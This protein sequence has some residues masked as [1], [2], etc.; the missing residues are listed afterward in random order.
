MATTSALPLRRLIHVLLIALTYPHLFSSECYMYWAPSTIPGA[1]LGVFAGSKSYEVGDQVTFGDLVIPIWDLDWH[2][3]HYETRKFLWDEY[4]WGPEVFDGM[5]VEVTENDAIYAASIGMGA[6]PN[7]LLP[8]INLYDDPI[9]LDNAG[10]DSTSPGVGSFTPYH[11]RVYRAS[12]DIQP[13]MELFVNYG[14]NYFDSRTHIYGVMPFEEDYTRADKLLLEYLRFKDYYFI[15]EHADREGENDETDY[16]AIVPDLWSVLQDFKSIWTESTVLMAVPEEE[17]IIKELM[18][19]GGTKYTLYDRSIRDIAWLEEHGECM[20]NIRDGTSTIPHA[21]RGAFANRK[22]PKGSLVSPVP[23]IH[24]SD[25]DYLT[26]YEMT[27]YSLTP[28][29]TVPVHSQLL[30]N[31]CFGHPQSQLMLCPYGMLTASINHAHKKP[32]IK[33]EWSKSTSMRHPEWKDM[34][35]HKW[36]NELHAGLSFDYVALRDIEEGEEILL[37]YGAA[38]DKAWKLHVR[39][40]RTMREH[41]LPAFELNEIIDDNLQIRTMDERSY[42]TDSVYLFCRREFAEWNGLNDTIREMEE[43]PCRVLER[44]EGGG[45]GETTYVAEVVNFP[46]D[47]DFCERVGVGILWNVTRD[48]FYFED[49]PYERDH[50]QPW[51]FRHEMHIPDDMFPEIWKTTTTT[52]TTTTKKP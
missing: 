38:W 15:E 51:T 40:Y 9:Q 49:M 34:P 22:L 8:L 29:R 47:T 28:N 10:L 35:V 37:D 52:T 21:G 3:E 1:G 32:N 48:A 41:Y 31:Y 16:Q 42:F 20:D 27:D 2:Q 26:T 4:V 25:K 17:S 14:F 24:I 45:D 43:L 39:N 5:E 6:A 46:K 13:G 11:G 19:E 44:R 23:L 36:A 12:Q 50:H 30:R 33:I 7:C 18:D